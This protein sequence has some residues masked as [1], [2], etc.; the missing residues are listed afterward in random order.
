MN[1]LVPPKVFEVYQEF[2]H[3][4]DCGH[5]YWQGSHVERILA[6]LAKVLG[7]KA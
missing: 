4:K 3:C 7:E 6:N 5:I 1:A 2:Y